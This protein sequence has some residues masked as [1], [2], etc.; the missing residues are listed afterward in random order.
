MKVFN[1]LAELAGDIFE[2]TDEKHADLVEEG[3]TDAEETPDY[4]IGKRENPPLFT[5]FIDNTANAELEYCLNRDNIWATAVGK[6]QEIEKYL[7]GLW[8]DLLKKKM[9]GNVF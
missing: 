7:I 1:R 3:F 2:I 5:E 6:E 8:T 4:N 9:L